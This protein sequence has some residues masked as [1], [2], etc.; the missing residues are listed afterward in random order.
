MRTKFG[1]DAQVKEDNV[2]G[3]LN[4]IDQVAATGVRTIAAKPGF[5]RASAHLDI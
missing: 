4:A 2:W 3:I 1:I 5:Y